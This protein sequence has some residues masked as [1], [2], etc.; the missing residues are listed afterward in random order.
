MIDIAVLLTALVGFTRRDELISQTSTFENFMIDSLAPLQRGISVM[1]A[2]VR[3][4]FTHYF[5]NVSASKDNVELQRG[6]D[7]LK[8]KLFSFEELARENKRLKDL[9][10]FGAEIH[11]EKV[12]ARVI[13]WDATSDAKVLRL[14]K[15]SRD[16]L[17]LQ[18]TVVTSEGLVGYVYR[19]TDHF[20]DVLTILDP[21]NRVDVLIERTRSHGILEGFSTDRCVL[22]YVARSEPVIL[23]DNLITSGMGNIYPKGI[24]VGQIVRIERESY[25][26]TQYIEVSPA[27]YF[28]RLEEV[29]VLVGDSN[30]VK[31]KELEALDNGSDDLHQGDER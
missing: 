22:K 7:E 23:A 3:D 20:A 16:G 14:N 25:G 8:G 11:Y 10:S 9:L 2:S 5:A 18:S 4:V 6:V 13:A 30:P 24:K 21:N 1:Q 31:Q 29:V 28:G 27:V 17:R 19:L 15:G 12:L 26:I